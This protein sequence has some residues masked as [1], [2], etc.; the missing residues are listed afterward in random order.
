MGSPQKSL[1]E[2]QDFFICISM[3]CSKAVPHSDYVRAVSPQAPGCLGNYRS[4]P[5]GLCEPCLFATQKEQP[6]NGPPSEVLKGAAG[7][8]ICISMLC[9]KAP[10]GFC[11][12][13]LGLA[14]GMFGKQRDFPFVFLGSTSSLLP[15]SRRKRFRVELWASGPGQHR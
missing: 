3:C 11:E 13:D 2:L 9:S 6:Y 8:F 5:I 15:G 7:F 12:F 10:F 4:S 1:R 14:T